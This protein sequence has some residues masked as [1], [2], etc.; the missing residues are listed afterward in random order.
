MFTFCGQRLGNEESRTL[1]PPKPLFPAILTESSE[2]LSSGKPCRKFWKKDL[3]PEISGTF[4]LVCSY[5][6]DKFIFTVLVV[7]KLE[8][9]NKSKFLSPQF[10]NFIKF[11]YIPPA[12]EGAKRLR[13]L[14]GEKMEVYIILEC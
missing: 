5:I 2:A 4:T 8:S 9:S 6:T 12:D 7:D 10:M 11:C 14:S 1:M 3:S 13:R